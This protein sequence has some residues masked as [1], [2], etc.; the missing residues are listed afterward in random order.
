[1]FCKAGRWR[2][3]LEGAVTK[4]AIVF[5]LKCN[6]DRGRGYHALW[7]ITGASARLL[8]N[9]N[10]LHFFFWPFCSPLDLP[11]LAIWF[12]NSPRV[13]RALID[14][15]LV[16]EGK[17]DYRLTRLGWLWYSN[18]MFY[19]IPASEQNILKQ[20]VFERLDTPGRDITQDELIYAER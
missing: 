18:I 11:L 1:M 8:S 9:D 17:H 19:L 16:V 5:F 10:A 6:L 4:L 7:D 13:G 2:G 14:A 3:L 12:T 20:L 15:D